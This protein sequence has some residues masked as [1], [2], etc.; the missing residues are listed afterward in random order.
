MWILMNKKTAQKIFAEISKTCNIPKQDLILTKQSNINEN[1][2]IHI[3]KSLEEKEWLCI[4]EIT[5][6]QYLRL[7][8]ADKKIILY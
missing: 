6:N 4:E 8:L 7:K 5:T 1:Y 3:E 2:E